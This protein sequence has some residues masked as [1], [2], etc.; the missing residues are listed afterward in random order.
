M[1]N[2]DYYVKFREL[3]NK[4]LVGPIPCPDCTNPVVFIFDD[5]DQP[6]TY[7]PWCGESTSPGTAFWDNIKRIVEKYHV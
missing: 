6:M 2:W 1:D 3:V 4:K 5:D 7:C